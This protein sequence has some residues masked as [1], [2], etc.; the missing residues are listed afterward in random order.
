MRHLLALILIVLLVPAVG[1]AQETQPSQTYSEPLRTEFTAASSTRF[2]F[3]KTEYVMDI[4][5]LDSD[6]ARYLLKS[7][8]EFPLDVPLFGAEFTLDLLRGQQRTWQFSLG[9][10]TNLTD[11]N[12]TMYDSD[13]S[14][15]ET[16]TY[17]M[18]SYTESDAE[19]SSVL[20]HARAGRV[21]HHTPA[22]D[23]LLYGGLHFQNINQDVIGFKG[24]QLD[25]LANRYY[26]DIENVKGIE[27]EV[28]YLMPHAGLAIAQT[29]TP[30]ITA[31]AH[32]AY[33]AVFVS[34]FDDHVLRYKTAEA[35]I[36]GNGLL[37]GLDFT[38]D[39]GRNRGRQ[40]FISFT[41]DL[42]LVRASGAQTQTW[43]ED[44]LGFDPDTGETVVRVEK[45]TTLTGLPHDINTTQFH[46]GLMFG[47]RF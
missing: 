18:F 15:L 10:W 16:D 26:F 27:Y 12:G 21:I 33:A 19:M 45:G 40:T 8:L 36:T 46:A 24:W 1:G 42:I 3:G 11:P 25:E 32:A 30:S 22:T 35:D 13:W 7:Q 5:Q 17:E 39:I 37:A 9:I 41:G 2:S 47:V 43:Y 29:F 28:T 44:E 20:L 23:V 34:D 38:V 6:G 31:G 14:N 4:N